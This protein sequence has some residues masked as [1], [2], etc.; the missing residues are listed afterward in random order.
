MHSYLTARI[1]ELQATSS[2]GGVHLKALEVSATII[3]VIVSH[4]K[5]VILWGTLDSRV[6]QPRSQVCV[7]QT[8]P[9]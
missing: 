2:E 6:P 9:G 7:E 5:F 1:V 8:Q 4:P 3:I